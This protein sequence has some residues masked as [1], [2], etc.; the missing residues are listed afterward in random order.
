MQVT[1]DEPLHIFRPEAKNRT[2]VSE[3]DYRN[4]RIAAGCM[5]THPRLGDAQQFG[6]VV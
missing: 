6:H 4:P 5:I 1:I 2:L 3:A